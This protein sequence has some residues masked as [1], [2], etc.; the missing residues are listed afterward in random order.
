M[1]AVA[2]LRQGYERFLLGGVG[3]H[4]DVNGRNRAQMEVLMLKRGDPDYHMAMDA[5]Q[6]LGADWQE[7][8]ADGIKTCN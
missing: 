1:A 4:S 3:T 6:V 7:K 8:V 2:T 5:K